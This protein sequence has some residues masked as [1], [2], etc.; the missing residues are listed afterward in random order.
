VSDYLLI[1]KVISSH[2]RNGTVKIVSSFDFKEIFSKLEKDFYGFFGDKKLLKVENIEEGND[3][4]FLKIKNFDSESDSE[5]L[6]GKNIFVDKN[7]L[8]ELPE[9]HFFVHDLIGSIVFCNDEK[10]G[11]IK[12]VLKFPANDVYV[13]LDVNNSERLIPDVPEFIDKF[14][15]KKKV[16]ILKKLDEYYEEDDED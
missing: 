14:D 9:D 10:I 3:C 13:I 1:A 4:F 11:K 7:D 12:D 5:I 2:G 6:I 15:P 8:L 16:L